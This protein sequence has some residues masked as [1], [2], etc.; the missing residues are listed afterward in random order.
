MKKWFC[1]C[2]LLVALCVMSVAYADAV[3]GTCGDN[4]TWSLENGTLTISGTGAMTD[5]TSTDHAPWYD[6]GADIQELSIGAGVTKIGAYA[7]D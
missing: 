1:G 3:T 2:L 6:Y 7:F 5:Y 4:L